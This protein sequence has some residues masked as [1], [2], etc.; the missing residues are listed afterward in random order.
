VVIEASVG[1]SAYILLEGTYHGSQRLAHAIKPL[2]VCLFVWVKVEMFG[3]S[4]PG[5]WN[6]RPPQM[7]GSAE[8][9]RAEGFGRQPFFIRH[10]KVSGGRGL[11]KC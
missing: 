6:V 9:G 5:L 4:G 7:M 3:R 2:F 11:F 8:A 1:K 10:D